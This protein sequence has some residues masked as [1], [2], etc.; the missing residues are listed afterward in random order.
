MSGRRMS[1]TAAGSWGDD[2]AVALQKGHPVGVGFDAPG[3]HLQVGHGR[4]AL[5]VPHQSGRPPEPPRARANRGA[6]GHQAAGM[7]FLGDD[8]HGW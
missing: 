8:D 7:E 4:G 6:A 5:D 2:P 3:V 1:S